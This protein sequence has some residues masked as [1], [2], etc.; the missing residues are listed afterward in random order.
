MKITKAILPAAAIVLA[1]GLAACGSTPAPAAAPA[2]RVAQT[3]IA[4]P[5]A[6]TASPAP[7][8]TVTASPSTPQVNININNNPAPG[9]P[10]VIQPIYAAKPGVTNPWAVVSEYY[11]L[12]E[13][14]DFIDAWNLLSPGF[15]DSQSSYSSWAGGYADTG[16]Q[17]LTLTS[18]SGDTVDVAIDAVDTATGDTQY[19]TGSYTVDGGMIT[20]GWMTYQGES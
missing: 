18:E 5:S 20:S 2:G 8:K 17:T 4:T 7:T 6:T 19:F 15:Q 10:V 3:V 13:T 12:V 9:V 16:A 11:G 14:G 1:A